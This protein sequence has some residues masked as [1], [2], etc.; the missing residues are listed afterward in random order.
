MFFLYLVLSWFELGHDGKHKVYSVSGA[1]NYSNIGASRN[2]I[3]KSRFAK[4]GI[5]AL[6][7]EVNDIM[8]VMETPVATDSVWSRGKSDKTF[9]V[10][11]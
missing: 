9:Q 10:S 11:W 2:A 4:Q 6:S 5:G 1:Q 8:T 3:V 7:L